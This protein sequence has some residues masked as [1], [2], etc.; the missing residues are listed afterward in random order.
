M[1]S[2]TERTERTPDGRALRRALATRTGSPSTSVR[3]GERRR[4]D[5][6]GIKR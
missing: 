5:P 3:G 1:L 2:R 6:R 4:A